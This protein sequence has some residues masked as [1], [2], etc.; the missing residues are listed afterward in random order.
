MICFILP[1]VWVFFWFDLSLS[2]SILVYLDRLLD[3]RILYI[4]I[5]QRNPDSFVYSNSGDL[6]PEV[7]V[8]AI[9]GIL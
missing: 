9:G 2:L 6:T 4:P 7:V 8:N 3:A 1:L 5:G